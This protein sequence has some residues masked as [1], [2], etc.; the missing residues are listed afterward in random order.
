MDAQAPLAA[1]IWEHTP[2]VAQEMILAQATV[3]ASCG[4]SGAV[5]A[6]VEELTQRLRRT[7]HNSSSRPRLIHPRRGYDPVVSPVG[8]DPVGS[9]GMKGRRGVGPGEASMYS[10]RQAHAV[11]RCQ[12]PLRG[13]DLQ[14]QRHQVA[15]LPQ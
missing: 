7:S 10:F 2:P 6:T 15:E 1:E 8:V 11:P 12:H 14:P 4:R 3:L 9:P 5:K 13:E